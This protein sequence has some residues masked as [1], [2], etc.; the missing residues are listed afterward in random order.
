MINPEES[1]Y[2]SRELNKKCHDKENNI[3]ALITFKLVFTCKQKSKARYEHIHQ[4]HSLGTNKKSY[5]I[6]T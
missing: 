5:Y 2:S 6:S 4:C 1:D 3:K